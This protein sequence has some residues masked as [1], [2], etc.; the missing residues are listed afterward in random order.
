VAGV[1]LTYEL[2]ARVTG[3]RAYGAAVG[4]ALA[5]ASILVWANA[6]VGVIGSEDNPANSMYG[7]VLAVGMVGALIA[8]FRPYGM[9]RALVATALARALAGAIAPI[10]GM[11]PPGPGRQLDILVLTV[12]F[13][14]AHIGVAVPE[15]GAG[16]APGGRSAVGRS[17]GRRASAP[18]QCMQLV[19]TSIV[20]PSS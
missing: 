11:A 8:R 9:A 5:A 7:G 4:V 6:A 17:D 18:D 19:R 12:F 3:S 10:A 1:D 20:I 15:S 14:V 2:A 16:A 13:A